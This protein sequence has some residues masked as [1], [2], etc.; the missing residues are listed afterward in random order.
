[1]TDGGRVNTPDRSRRDK[2]RKRLSADMLAGVVAAGAQ[3]G[4]GKPD[5]QA[6]AAMTAT[7]AQPKIPQATTE[8]TPVG[9]ATE[10]AKPEGATQPPTSTEAQD[11]QLDKIKGVLNKDSAQW[12]KTFFYKPF[13]PPEPAPATAP[14]PVSTADVKV[15]YNIYDSGNKTIAQSPDG[16]VKVTARSEGNYTLAMGLT[17]KNGT[18]NPVFKAGVESTSEGGATIK[19]GNNEFKYKGEVKVDAS[20]STDMK[21][22][23]L[24]KVKTGV[25]VGLDTALERLH[26][27]SAEQAVSMK[28][29]LN[30]KA[31]AELG[32]SLSVK[33]GVKVKGELGGSAGAGIGGGFHEAGHSINGFAGIEFGAGAAAAGSF[34]FSD[35][36]ANIS[37]DLKLALGVGAKI[38]FDMTIDAKEGYRA[39]DSVKADMQN[40]DSAICKALAMNNLEEFERLSL[41]AFATKMKDLAAKRSDFFGA[42]Y[43][44][45]AK[46]AETYSEVSK[47]HGKVLGALAATGASTATIV[48]KV[49][50]GTVGHVFKQVIKLF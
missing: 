38:K 36:K 6:I 4:A 14:K 15:K 25:E 49:Y 30:A 19:L 33:E 22:G 26:K 44:G 24:M 28:A 29:V 50:S 47:T 1:M 23:E 18:L 13:F 3:P 34:S 7:D 42:H 43:A 16:A 32:M 46:A 27:V 41:K 12:E 5:E 9:K 35:G 11:W 45:A 20:I 8:A 37:I 21:N 17:D 31:A 10:P 2:G 39:I 40:P 48:S